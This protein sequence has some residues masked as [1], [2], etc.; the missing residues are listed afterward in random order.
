MTHNFSF[1]VV[2]CLFKNSQFKSNQDNLRKASAGCLTYKKWSISCCLAIICPGVVGERTLCMVLLVLTPTLWL[3][4]DLDLNGK[5]WGLGRFPITVQS[6]LSL[7]SS[8]SY[9]GATVRK[10]VPQCF[11]KALTEG[12]LRISNSLWFCP[13]KIRCSLVNLF[14]PSLLQLCYMLC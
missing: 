3:L 10:W 12:I 4:S 6:S 14:A 7:C 5:P 11:F 13:L 9:L 8:M 1:L 2:R